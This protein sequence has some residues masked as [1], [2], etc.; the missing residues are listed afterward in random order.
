[1]EAKEFRKIL[2]VL[3]AGNQHAS[4]DWNGI[5][6]TIWGINTMLFSK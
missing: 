6:R 2:S 5:P 1:M 3:D 4:E